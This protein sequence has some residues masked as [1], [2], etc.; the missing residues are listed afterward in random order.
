M[1]VSLLMSNIPSTLRYT[2]AHS[3]VKQED[4]VLV[5]GITDYAQIS[6]GDIVFVEL[7]E[8]GMHYSQDQQIGMIES[9]KTG[10]DIYAPV[11]GKVLEVNN[12]LSVTPELINDDPY[13]AWIYKILPASRV[14][15]EQLL[16]AQEYNGLVSE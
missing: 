10:S 3:W 14:E 1:G 16:S 7:P 11:T 12:E 8:D 4:D 5:V 9:V 13:S 6:L 2:K 15:F